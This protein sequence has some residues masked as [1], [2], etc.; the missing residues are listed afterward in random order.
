[1]R[2]AYKPI[3][4]DAAFSFQ[5]AAVHAVSTALAT[6]HGD[7]FAAAFIAEHLQDI[8]RAARTRLCGSSE[9][10]AKADADRLESAYQDV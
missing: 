10:A 3:Q 6:T 9:A 4:L 1:M 2:P 5:Q 8:L 7:D